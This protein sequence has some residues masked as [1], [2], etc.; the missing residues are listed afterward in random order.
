MTSTRGVLDYINWNVPNERQSEFTDLFGVKMKFVITL[1]I[2]A[3]AAVVLCEEDSTTPEAPPAP[4]T[5]PPQL[6][7]SLK[8]IQNV[9]LNFVPNPEQFKPQFE[10]IN[11]MLSGFFGGRSKRSIV[12]EI[13]EA[14]LLNEKEKEKEKEGAKETK[15][16]NSDNK[17]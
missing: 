16:E 14:K 6:A 4:F 13:M 7:E 3:L 8:N 10:R 1:V 9:L 17:H 2:L 11:T 5:P 15:A 12:K